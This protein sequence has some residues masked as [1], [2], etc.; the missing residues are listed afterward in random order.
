MTCVEFPKIGTGEILAFKAKRDVIL[1]YQHTVFFDPGAVLILY[2][3][4]LTSMFQIFFFQQSFDSGQI[5]PARAAVESAGARQVDV[6][7]CLLTQLLRL[8]P[9]IFVGNF[10]VCMKLTKRVYK[11]Q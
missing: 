5:M 6:M 8:V 3:A 11:L 10:S 1:S 2:S 9:A 4:T 7:K